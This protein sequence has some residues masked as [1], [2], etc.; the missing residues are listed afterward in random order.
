M[1]A[2]HWVPTNIQDNLFTL[3]SSKGISLHLQLHL[4]NYQLQLAEQTHGQHGGLVVSTVA[5]Q[6]DGSGFKPQQGPLC[7]KF[8]CSPCA[9]MGFL[10]GL[11][12]LP[13]K[14]MHVGLIGGSKLPM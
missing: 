1:P 6:Q 7:M 5:S 13:P 4:H 14:D 10:L 11:L 3:S 12:Q 2:Y 8:A 9:Y